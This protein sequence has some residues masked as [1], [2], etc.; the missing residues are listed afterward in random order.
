MK[1]LSE[2]FVLSKVSS[3]DTSESFKYVLSEESEVPELGPGK[4]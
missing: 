4:M 3:C 2:N 1:I